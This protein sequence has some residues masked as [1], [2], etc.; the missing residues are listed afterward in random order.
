MGW[1]G[2]TCKHGDPL[3]VSAADDHTSCTSRSINILRKRG[4][5][6]ILK[7]YKTTSLLAIRAYYDS[8]SLEATQRL[9]FCNNRACKY[10]ETTFSR[11][12]LL[13][14]VPVPFRIAHLNFCFIIKKKKKKDSIWVLFLN[15]QHIF[16]AASVANTYWNKKNP[17]RAFPFLSKTSAL[18]P[19]SVKVISLFLPQCIAKSYLLLIAEKLKISTLLMGFPFSMKSPYQVGRVTEQQ[20]AHYFVE[21]VGG[22]ILK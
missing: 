3:S 12:V 19:S 13:S 18:F 21:V 16:K 8:T 17:N 10:H 15:G 1:H 7:T 20:I 2:S 14:L 11:T 9:I 6:Y 5:K 4:K 22:A